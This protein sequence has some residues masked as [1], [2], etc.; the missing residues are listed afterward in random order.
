MDKA[1]AKVNQ[2]DLIDMR[3]FSTQLMLYLKTSYH[4]KL[5]EKSYLS[6]QNPTC[7]VSILANTV[8]GSG[9]SGQRSLYTIEIN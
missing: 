8:A 1:I 6:E 9:V 7:P 2:N 5:S 4:C 3:I